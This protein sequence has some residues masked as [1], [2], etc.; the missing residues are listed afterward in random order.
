[1]QVRTI[2]YVVAV[3]R[4]HTTWSWRFVMRSSAV[5]RVWFLGM[6]LAASGCGDATGPSGGDHGPALL[7]GGRAS[8]LAAGGAVYQLDDFALY[9]PATAGGP[10]AVLVALGGPNTKGFASG[11]PF[12]APLPQVEA[13]L[14]AMGQSLRELA[15]ERG[16]AILGTSLAAMP[17]ALESD[18]RILAALS[19][20]ADA[21]GQ[22]GLSGLPI[23]LYGISGGGP[24]ASEFAA[25]HADRIAGLVL[26]APLSVSAMTSADQREVP[27]FMVLAQFD[28][29]VD[30][31]ALAQAFA[32]NRGGGAL[33]A[34]GMEPG[35]PHHS[36][37]P[38]HKAATIEWMRSILGHRLAGSSGRLRTISEQSGWLADPSTGTVSSWGAYTR[39]PSGVSWFPTRASAMQWLVLTGAAPSS[40]AA[41]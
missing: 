28:A 15:D 14:Q 35:V 7:Q 25:R 41:D 27:T 39:D 11:E 9:M 37:S 4:K 26:K 22:G 40:A 29:F 6:V 1:M 8:A 24:E 19:A 30:N 32:A 36:L 5:V 18:A 33:W 16:L 34:M 10:R 2:P 38:S 21:S 31:V 3:C 20:A 12:G 17:A 13:A 23:L